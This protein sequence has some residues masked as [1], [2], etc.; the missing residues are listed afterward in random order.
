MSP[1]LPNL[2]P[3]I[4]VPA[5]IGLIL[6]CLLSALG[7]LLYLLFFKSIIRTWFEEKARYQPQGLTEEQIIQIVRKEIRDERIR[8]P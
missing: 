4:F 8:N 1:E 2:L 3:F 7:F 5:L 6:A